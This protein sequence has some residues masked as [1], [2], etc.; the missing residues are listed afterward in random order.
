M[1]SF[2]QRNHILALF[3]EAISAGARQHT[4]C[5]VIDIDPGTLRRWRP[6]GQTK[7]HSDARPE[8]LRPL[9]S[10]SYSEAERAHI[11]E[12]CNSKEY[13]SLPP[14]QIVP[15]L[16]DEGLYIGSESTFYRVLKAADQQHTRGRAK[17]RQKSRAPTTHTADGPNQVWMMDVT[18]LPSRVRGQYFYLYMVEDLY[19]R[20]GV[21]WEVFSEESSEHTCRVIEHHSA[22]PYSYTDTY[23]LGVL[24][25]CLAPAGC[26]ASLRRYGRTT[27]RRFA[28]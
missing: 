10:S 11:L 12:T 13:E 19:S 25:G 17:S 2:Q 14:S 24:V 1:S 5:E 7:V 9:P 26:L 4:A 27:T 16:A 22:T 18:W 23:L 6:A 8:A 28:A 15:R 21:H 20:F 3:D